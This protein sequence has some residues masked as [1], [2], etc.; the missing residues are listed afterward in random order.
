MKP[1]ALLA[2]LQLGGLSVHATSVTQPDN[3]TAIFELI[4]KPGEWYSRSEFSLTLAGQELRP[5]FMSSTGLGD[6]GAAIYVIADASRSVAGDWDRIRGYCAN[7]LEQ[8]RDGDSVSLHVL[9]P[10]ETADDRKSALDLLAHVEPTGNTPLNDQLRDANQFF[11]SAPK[12]D[13]FLVIV[14]DGFDDGSKSSSI[15]NLNVPVHF[16]SIRSAAPAM[17]KQ[18]AEKTGGSTSTLRGDSGDILREALSATGTSYA[19]TFDLP[20][21]EATATNAEFR[22]GETRKGFLLETPVSSI[23][24][25]TNSQGNRAQGIITGLVILNVVLGVTVLVK[26]RMR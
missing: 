15:P 4:A 11:A 7:L 5:K 3:R 8:T 18:L 17:M 22:A 2:L 23:I 20:V 16:V 10:G 24:E 13:R 1:L 21:C 6:V 9:G 19:V 14:S 12:S 25:S 26:R